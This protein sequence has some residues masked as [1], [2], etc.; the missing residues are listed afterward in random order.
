M[1]AEAGEVALL[2]QEPGASGEG[3]GKCV[4]RQVRQH[5]VQHGF[6]HLPKE[7]NMVP[8]RVRSQ[9]TLKPSSFQQRD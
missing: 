6:L 7:T 8:N 2:D 4:L 5:R 1:A 9:L 3:A